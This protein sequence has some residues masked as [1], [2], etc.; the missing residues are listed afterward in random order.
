MTTPPVRSVVVTP[1]PVTTTLRTGRVVV[2]ATRSTPFG[3]CDAAN[4]ATVTH[5]LQEVLMTATTVRRSKI[6]ALRDAESKAWLAWQDARATSNDAGN[7]FDLVVIA[8]QAFADYI[9]AR[10]AARTAIDE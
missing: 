7:P 2:P 8:S 10:D 5:H 4:V 6:E 9:A 1:L 3:G